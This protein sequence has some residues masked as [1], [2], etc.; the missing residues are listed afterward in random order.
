MPHLR[1][2]SAAAGPGSGIFGLQ[3]EVIHEEFLIH[4]AAKMNCGGGGGGGGG[5]NWLAGVGKGG[6]PSPLL[7]GSASSWLVGYREEECRFPF[8]GGGVGVVGGWGVGPPRDQFIDTPPGVAASE[9]VPPYGTQAEQ[10]HFQSFPPIFP[11]YSRTK[12][13]KLRGGDRNIHI[14]KGGGRGGVEWSPSSRSRQHLPRI[15]ASAAS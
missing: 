14:K 11:F 9:A 7:V 3:L 4:V 6:V 12:Q 15:E 1:G 5:G 2:R 10:Q 8:G 13:K